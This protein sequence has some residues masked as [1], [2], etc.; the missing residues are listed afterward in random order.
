MANPRT[1]D[2]VLDWLADAADDNSP[3]ETGTIHA[4]HQSRLDPGAPRWV[5]REIP[6]WA[7]GAMLACLAF[8]VMVWVVSDSPPADLA[9]NV[10]I[11]IPCTTL[12][13]GLL[14]GSYANLVVDFTTGAAYHERR[15]GWFWRKRTPRPLAPLDVRLVVEVRGEK[16]LP[17]AAFGINVKWRRQQTNAREAYCLQRRYCASVE[18]VQ[19]TLRQLLPVARKVRVGLACELV[20]RDGRDRFALADLRASLEGEALS[21]HVEDPALVRAV[22]ARFLSPETLERVKRATDVAPPDPPHFRAGP[23][24]ETADHGPR[25]SYLLVHS[26]QWLSRREYKKLDFPEVPRELPL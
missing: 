11:A 25:G 19:E 2:S 15:L 5:L 23:G 14:A 1:A 6:H 8:I 22:F 26:H 10:A 24:R 17:S 4:S 16:V 20:T 9:L 13:C 7:R 18:E 21:A 3:L 12:A